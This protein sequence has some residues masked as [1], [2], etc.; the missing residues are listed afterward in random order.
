MLDRLAKSV[1]HCGP[2]GAGHAVKAV[3]NAL[4][5]AHF[6]VAA[7]GLLCL[8]RL[9]IESGA[10]ARETK[11]PK[12]RRTPRPRGLGRA[13]PFGPARRR[14]RSRRRG[15]DAG[16]TALEAINAAS[17]RSLQTSERIP[18]FVVPRTFDFGFS[19]ELL[20]KDLGVAG[21]RGRRTAFEM[22]ALGAPRRGVCSWERPP[23]NSGRN[24]R[25]DRPSE[26]RDSPPRN[27]RAAAAAPPRLASTEHPRGSRGVAAIRLLKLRAAKV[28]AGADR[29]SAVRAPFLLTFAAPDCWCRPLEGAGKA[30]TDGRELTAQVA[31]GA[32][33]A[34]AAPAPVLRLV[35]SAIADCAARLPADAEH[36][37]LVPSPARY[38]VRDS[39]IRQNVAGMFRSARAPQR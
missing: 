13:L 11:P 34:V 31:V 10:A 29:I 24:S 28:P 36:M 32:L 19:L 21:R 17:G 14:R 15:R 3:N 18:T 25:P 23:G 7:E 30:R 4:L 9:G 1:A 26:A 22:R 6:V 5:A 37:E 8:K 39:E 35:D 33:D 16:A 27:I 20:R 12:R 38:A 2:A